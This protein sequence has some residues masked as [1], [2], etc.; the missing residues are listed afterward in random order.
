MAKVPDR[1]E[2]GQI[3]IDRVVWKFNNECEFCKSNYY[4]VIFMDIDMPVK[5]GF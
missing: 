3:G 4:R 1:A 5:D 2:N